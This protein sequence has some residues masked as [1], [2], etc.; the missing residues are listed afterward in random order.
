MQLS[1]SDSER[2]LAEFH[3]ANPGATSRAFANLPASMAGTAFASSYECLA[4]VVPAGARTVLDLA[5]GDGFLLALLAARR[6]AGLSLVGVDLS[7]GELAAARRRLGP[8]ALLHQGLARELPLG[9]LAADV[10]LCH[11]ALMLMDDVPQVLAEVRRVLTPGGVFSAVIGGGSASPAHQVFVSLLREYRKLPQFESLRLGDRRLQSPE[12][13]ADLFAEDF[14]PP[15]IDAIVLQWR[16]RPAAL[17]SWF[18]K[19]YD[20]AWLDV[21]D[22]T[23]IE[24]RFAQA[25]EPLCD[26]G[27]QLEHSVMLR[28]ITA[29]ARPG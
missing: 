12:G 23:L 5:C 2:F 11:M 13:I 3:D 17:W 20:M 26:A 14:E 19:M 18:D 24:R 27:G 16:C 28:R 4:S 29:R 6:Q 21:A 10:V 22:A 7:T 8:A 25:V 9:D 1:R 15:A